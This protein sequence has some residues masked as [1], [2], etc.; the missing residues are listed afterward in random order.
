MGIADALGL[1]EAEAL[2]MSEKLKDHEQKRRPVRTLDHAAA[3]IQ[4]ARWVGTVE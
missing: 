2:R 4:L 1:S 3:E